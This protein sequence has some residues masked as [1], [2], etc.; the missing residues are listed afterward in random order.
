[1]ENKEAI[2]ILQSMFYTTD[3]DV[4]H[5]I[6]TEELRQEHNKALQMAI[7]SLEQENDNSGKEIGGVFLSYQFL[8]E[9]AKEKFAAEM[10]DDQCIQTLININL[11]GEDELSWEMLDIHLNNA[12]NP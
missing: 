6:G 10:T 5:E 3:S 12:I 9:R 1:M 7:N 2:E 8:R 4:K 11:E